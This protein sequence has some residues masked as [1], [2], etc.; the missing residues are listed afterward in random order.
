MEFNLYNIAAY[1]GRIYCS[2]LG[3]VDRLDVM[4]L[5]DRIFD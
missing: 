5:V 2:S 4:E 1:V 3:P